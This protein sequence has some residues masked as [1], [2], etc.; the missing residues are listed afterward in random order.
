VDAIRALAE[1][2]TVQS[3]PHEVGSSHVSVQPRDKQGFAVSLSVMAG[4]Y[5][6]SFDGWHEDFSDE[7]EAVA[8]FMFG[9]CSRCRLRVTRRWGMSCAWTVEKKDGDTWRPI[10]ETGLLLAPWWAK[11]SFGYLQN[12]W[13]EP[14]QKNRA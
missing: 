10:S 14:G 8:C 13:G 4:Q 12:E 1:R 9:L 7:H 11:K 6:V 2:L 3:I 5:T